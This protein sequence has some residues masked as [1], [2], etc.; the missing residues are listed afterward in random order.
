MRALVKETDN[1]TMRLFDVPRPEPGPGEVLVKVRAAAVCGTDLHIAQW[2]PWAQRAGIRLPL[3][4]GHEFSGEV[5]ALGPDVK[6]VRA[7]DYVAGETHVPCGQCFQCRNGLQ[8]ICGNLKL[9]GIHRDGCFAEYATIPAICAHR[10]P[11]TIPPNVAAMLEPLGTSV[12]AVLEVH[13]AGETVAVLGCGPIG[14]FAIAAAKA[15]GAA[16]VIA[17]DVREERLKLAR[18]V[19]ADLTLDARQVKV[20]DVILQETGGVGVDAI[21]EASGSVPAIEG[22]WKYLRKGGK[23]A[24]IGLPSDPVRVNLGPDV[25]FK[26][27][28][29]IGIH[30]REMFATWTRMEHM[31][32]RGMLRVDPVITHEMPLERWA[33]AFRLLEE[34][35]GGKVI[36]T[37]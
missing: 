3:V 12:R 27:A 17:T 16:R 14:L 7:G 24:L 21:V 31:L 4:M 36:L 37:P 19:G 23:V 15:A 22:A 18:A 26:E 10:I 1:T 11:T 34:G 6:G 29:I 2:T 30:G 9:F 5:V 33:E 20:A 28:R 25:I 8:H 13:P 35:Q 32:E